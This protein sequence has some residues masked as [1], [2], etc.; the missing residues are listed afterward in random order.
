M[1][2]RSLNRDQRGF[3]LATTLW[4]IA[5]M[6]MAAAVFSDWASRSL[7][8]AAILDDRARAEQKFREI[9]AEV[10]YLLTTQPVSLRGIELFYVEDQKLSFTGGG[11]PL[12][13]AYAEANHYLKVN[14]HRYDAG[15]GFTVALQDARGLFNFNLASQLQF[16]RF[17]SLLGVP[18]EEHDS[19]YD[20]L[21]DY[22]DSDDLK[23][24][25]GGERREYLAAGLP[26][27]ANRPLS[28]HWDARRVLRWHTLTEAWESGFMDE[29]TTVTDIAGFNP[30]TAPPELLAIIPGLTERM[31]QNIVTLREAGPFRGHRDFINRGKGPI[32]SFDLTYNFLPGR[33]I[34][35]DVENAELH[36]RWQFLIKTTPNDV[37]RPWVIN[38]QV[39]QP[40][41]RAPADP[42]SGP[43]DAPAA[44]PFPAPSIYL[45][46]KAAKTL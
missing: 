11:D 20:S 13:A 9:R 34:R 26:P 44:T 32:A 36:L 12:V 41:R 5:I 39:K 6:A 33:V 35:V 43:E 46:A 37:R 23:K 29:M 17:L 24:L 27:P 45:L 14:G 38:Y 19:Y 10:I 42:A 15:G 21:Q 3:V 1:R 4:I 7:N 16:Y 2:P 22:K 31:I 18:S 30:N 25:N 40:L 8:S 28:T